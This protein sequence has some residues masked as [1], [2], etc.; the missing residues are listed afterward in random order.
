MHQPIELVGAVKSLFVDGDEKSLDD[1]LRTVGIE[2]LHR[3]EGVHDRGAD[4][5]HDQDDTDDQRQT[6]TAILGNRAWAISGRLISLRVWADS[7][8]PAIRE[9]PEPIP[10]VANS[11]TAFANALRSSDPPGRYQRSRALSTDKMRIE[12]SLGLMS[13]RNDPSFRPFSTRL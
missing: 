12:E 8:Y 11:S 9:P 6:L 5:S 1:T 13:V 2:W 10:L 7:T 4:Y 3:P